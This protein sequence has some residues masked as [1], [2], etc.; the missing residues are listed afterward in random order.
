MLVIGEPVDVVGATSAQT[1]ASVLANGLTAVS[2]GLEA[3]E[4][5]LRIGR[6]A[7]GGGFLARYGIAV[8]GL[9]LVGAMLGGASWVL[10]AFFGLGAQG[11]SEGG[12]LFMAYALLAYGSI[13]ALVGGVLGALE[14]LILGLPLAATIGKLNRGPG[15]RV[16]A[17]SL[18][19][20]VLTGL[21]AV[22]ALASY[23]TAPPP[24]SEAAG[25]ANTP[26]LSCPDNL[27]EE[28]ASID[29]PGDRT[30]PALETKGN[31][32]GFQHASAGPG[33][34][35]VRVLEGDG[36]A[37]MPPEPSLDTFEGAAPSSPSP[38]PSAWK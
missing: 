27:G 25:L 17:T 18:P 38:A 34:L 36:G 16:R 20:A 30:V 14:G 11:G 23:A 31:M 2:A 19:T 26:P 1:A 7:L 5:V 9:C 3:S 37:V 28:I 24:K 33:S 6:S 29:G 32:W 13:A 35:S 10:G 8:L 12:V 22:A 21:V 4:V 15:G